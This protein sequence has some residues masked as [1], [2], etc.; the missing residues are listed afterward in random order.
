MIRRSMKSRRL[1]GD[2]EMVQ[3]FDEAYGQRPTA[4]IFSMPSRL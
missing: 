2:P 3:E 4:R 1:N